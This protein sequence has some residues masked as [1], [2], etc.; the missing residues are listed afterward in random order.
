GEGE[1]GLSTTVE[2]GRRQGGTGL[3]V[4]ATVAVLALAGGIFTISSLA[5]FT[6]SESVAGNAFAAGS[7][8]LVATPAT[9]VVTASAMAPGDQQTASLDVANSGT[10][11]LRYAVTSTT[12]ED[13]LAGQLTLTIKSGVTTCD[14][15][16][17]AADG[18]VL[19]SGVLGTVATTTVFGDVTQ[20]S[21]AGDRVLAAG[22]N[23]ALCF[24]VSLPLGAANSAQGLSTTATFDFVAEQTANN[25]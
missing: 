4:L 17:W 14:D 13:V 8:D 25:P 6:D 20:G 2:P 16:N 23:E 1:P 3:K 11:E 19:Y 7:V 9:A 18:T 5:L 22:A 15:A 12:T 24:N 10:L 21:Q